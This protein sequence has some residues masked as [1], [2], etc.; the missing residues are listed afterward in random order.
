MADTDPAYMIEQIQSQS[1]E[2]Q[3]LNQE[4]QRLQGGGEGAPP[5]PAPA[6]VEAPDNF[7]MKE[8]ILHSVPKFGD[9][10]KILFR[11]HE[12]A[13]GK[14]LT[15][16]REYI[17][18]ESLK[19]TIVLESLIGRAVLRIKDNIAVDESY[20]NRTYEAFLEAVREVF[21]L[22]SERTFIPTEF[23]TYTQGR[24]QDN[25]AYLSIKMSLFK[26][27]CNSSERSFNTLLTYVIKG[28]HPVW[29]QV[30][31]TNPREETSLRT[32]VIEATAA[33]RDAYD[34]GCSEGTSAA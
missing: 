16:R 28:L 8:A 26:L 27:A 21:N 15:Y 34:G 20:T 2:I 18:T 3:R 25:Q 5:A 17:Q 13:L 1:A 11:D 6:P 31:R 22:D 23:T 33:E 9:D 29:R 10:G 19:K 24:Q 7:Q 14:F 30:R 12:C 4:L 32:A